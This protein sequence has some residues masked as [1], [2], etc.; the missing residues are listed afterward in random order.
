M[1]GIG[2][3]KL[4]FRLL[5]IVATVVAATVARKAVT[6]TWKLAAGDEPPANP[7][8]PRV[9]WK[10]AVTFAVVSGAVMGLA[11]MLA[12]RQAAAWFRKSTGHLP[13]DLQDASS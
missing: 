7:E 4:V 2:H 6:G 3:G 8:D 13:P 1:A 5:T 11:R 10:E 9:S 12:S